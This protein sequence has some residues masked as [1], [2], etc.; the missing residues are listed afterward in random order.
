MVLGLFKKNFTRH[1]PPSL[2]AFNLRAH[3]SLPLRMTIRRPINFLALIPLILRTI[4][5]PTL[6]H[7]PPLP[8]TLHL[9]R[10]RPTIILI[11]LLDFTTI[12]LIIFCFISNLWF[13]KAS[14][15][16]RRLC[17]ACKYLSFSYFLRVILSGAWL[18]FYPD[19]SHL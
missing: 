5:L 19:G 7:R 11:R 13:R 8:E 17:P 10:R 4:L 1:P 16:S 2:Q 9:S 14:I 12:P 15:A 6:I 3:P 18:H